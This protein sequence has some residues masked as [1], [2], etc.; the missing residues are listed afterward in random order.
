MNVRH[1]G[2]DTVAPGRMKLMLPSVTLALVGLV[3]FAFSSVW[4]IGSIGLSAAAATQLVRAIEVGGWA[5]A[6]TLTV[7]GGG[8]SGAI[9]AAIRW[10]VMTYG[11]T[12]AIA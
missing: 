7:L 10:R 12:I 3:A 4:V 9:V 8:I 11:R 6:I 1:L 5:L 2:G